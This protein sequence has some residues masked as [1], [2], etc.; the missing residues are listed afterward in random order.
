MMISLS[1]GGLGRGLGTVT[2]IQFRVIRPSFKLFDIPNYSQLIMIIPQG[3][4]NH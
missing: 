1:L 2:V 4:L 3:L